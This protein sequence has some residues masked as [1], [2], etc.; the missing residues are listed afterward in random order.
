MSPSD[1]G[2][3]AMNTRRSASLLLA[4]ALAVAAPA[5]SAD[6]PKSDAPAANGHLENGAHS[7]DDEARLGQAARDW[8]DW[9]DQARLALHGPANRLDKVRPDV[10]RELKQ[11]G[12]LVE[13]R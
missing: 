7:P 1:D 13:T 6:T 5:A 4:S 10:V 11:R 2:P 8:F 9:I 3:H 12:F